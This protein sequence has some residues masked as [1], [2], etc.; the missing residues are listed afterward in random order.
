M[1]FPHV[2]AVNVENFNI[3]NHARS[4]SRTNIFLQISID[5]DAQ[6]HATVIF[7]LNFYAT[8]RYILKH[9]VQ[10][11]PFRELRQI[12]RVISQVVL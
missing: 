6:N 12:Q 4:E 8:F 9:N 2:T 3:A 5:V 10:S 1:C 7:T 11:V